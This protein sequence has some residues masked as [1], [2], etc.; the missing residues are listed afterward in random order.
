MS[1]VLVVGDCRTKQAPITTANSPVLGTIIRET[2]RYR[3]RGIIRQLLSGDKDIC[4]VPQSLDV[5]PAEETGIDGPCTWPDHGE[6]GTK[7]GQHNG[8][9][10]STAVREN[11]TRLNHRY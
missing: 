7:Y 5:L 11:D 3:Y 6:T 10:R 1:I 4:L 2:G 9:P 8:R